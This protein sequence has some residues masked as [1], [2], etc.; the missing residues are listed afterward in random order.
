MQEK[1][2]LE[3]D[4]GG[5]MRCESMGEYTLPDYMPEVRR[6]VRL[7]TAAAIQGMYARGE[8]VEVGGECRYAL[9]YQGEDGRLVS[10]PLDGTF[11]CVLP[12]GEGGTAQASV[13]V[14]S[15]SCRPTGPRRVSL[16][17][18]LVLNWRACTRKDLP[19][20]DTDGG[21]GALEVLTHTM[22][23]GATFPFETRDLALTESVKVEPKSTPLSW[24][25]RVL[26]RE[27]RPEQDG[28][29]LRGEVWLSALLSREEGEPYR[30]KAKIPLEE[31]L[32]CPGATPLGMGMA[33]GACRNLVTQVTEGE[34]E[35]RLTFDLLCDLWGCVCENREAS[36]TADLYSL[37]YPCEVEYGRLEGRHYPFVKMGNFTVDG[38]ISTGEL[39]AGGEMPLVDTR[40]EAFVT[41]CESHGG[42]SVVTGNV[43]AS[44]IL[45]T[46]EEGYTSHT[47]TMPY[48]VRLAQGTALPEGAQL[49]AS[50]G[51]VGCHGRLDTDGI[52]VDAELC[53]RVLCTCPVSR[54]GV[55][56]WHADTD[57]PYP[58]EGG[59]VIAAYLGEGDSLWSIGKR[60]HVSQ[61]RLMQANSLP[62]EVRAEP[63]APYL[64]DG[65][66]RLVMERP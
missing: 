43:R 47:F 18:M 16:K 41:D 35:G 7:D 20:L 48:Q 63:D 42:E 45:G 10:A 52:R 60:Y 46:R 66:T 8:G 55:V 32:S 12:V 33:E 22:P 30:V 62:D 61:E 2:E 5:S 51:C 49:E 26:V 37:T 28:V 40:C 13:Q 27:V 19:S 50:V 9:L 25:G 23:L 38:G 56:S 1:Q 54:R 57:S 6:V 53:V 14:E 17:S 36:V 24:D 44:C 65:L 4:M 59:V 11:E 21:E 34:G 29:T 3:K 31:F 64:L 58:D 15:A 39:G